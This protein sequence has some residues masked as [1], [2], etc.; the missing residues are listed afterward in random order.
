MSANNVKMAETGEESS[1]PR[2]QINPNNSRSP[3]QEAVTLLE[4][5]MTLLREAARTETSLEN[6]STDSGSSVSASG[7]VPVVN[8]SNSSNTWEQR[9]AVNYRLEI[10]VSSN[11][12]RLFSSENLYNAI[13][14]L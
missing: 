1:E 6:S 11:N 9:A 13:Q 4:R 10:L 2:V 7:T 3:R 14:C 5:S 12:V 8:S